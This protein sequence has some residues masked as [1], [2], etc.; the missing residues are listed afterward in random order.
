MRKCALNREIS[1]A[2]LKYR[3][4]NAYH[5]SLHPNY[6]LYGI[7]LEN[8]QWVKIKQTRS[9]STGDRVF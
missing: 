9:S 7:V 2:V 5:P 8:T 3:F 6:K 1:N 4:T